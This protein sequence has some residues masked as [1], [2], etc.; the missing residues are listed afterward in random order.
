MMVPVE[1]L[2]RVREAGGGLR[3][4]VREFSTADLCALAASGAAADDSRRRPLLVLRDCRRLGV[5]EMVRIAELGRG[6][7]LLELD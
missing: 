3:L 4:S 7:V 5:E 1:E 2:K 6:S